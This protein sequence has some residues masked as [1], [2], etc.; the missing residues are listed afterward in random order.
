MFRTLSDQSYREQFTSYLY[1]M[2]YEISIYNF[3]QQF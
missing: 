2:V 1:Y 3:L